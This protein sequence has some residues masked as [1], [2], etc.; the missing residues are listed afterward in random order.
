MSRLRHVTVTQTRRAGLGRRHAMLADNL[1]RLRIAKGL[2]ASVVARMCGWDNAQQSRIERAQKVPTDNVIVK[3]LAAL[4]VPP[5]ETERIRADWQSLRVE[6][7]RA[8][9][10]FR[11]GAAA[12][13]QEHRDA[14]ADAV[15][16][17]EFFP[18]LIPGLFQTPGYARA[19]FRI[20]YGFLD[21]EKD[22]EAAVRKRM[23]RQKVLGT[24]KPIEIVMSE[25][26][27]YATPKGL[28]RQ[29]MRAQV[30][31]VLEISER[32]PH[33]HI[34]VIPIHTEFDLLAMNGYTLRE[35]STAT[36]QVVVEALSTTLK[37]DHPEDVSLYDRHFDR[38]LD[39]AACGRQARSLLDAA[40]AH[41]RG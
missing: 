7:L 37:I 5:G 26:V 27:L 12:V 2:K 32:H 29:D 25:S 38:L 36:G 16:I 39:G 10:R 21:V 19:I 20:L 34:G 28:S 9:D 23:D 14:E 24:G 35:T 11:E 33:V 31:R 40:I 17:R 6:V 8:V 41:Y 4:D 3:L 13:Q 22:I 1:R 18:V 15:R 30:E